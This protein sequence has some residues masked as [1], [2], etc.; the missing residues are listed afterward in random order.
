M[1]AGHFTQRLAEFVTT[2]QDVPAAALA[3][4]TNAVIDTVGCA[5]AGLDEAVVRLALER[6]AL[7]GARPVA[8]I[9][10]G[11]LASSAGLAALV[12]G[13]AAHV[14]DYDDG[15][16]SLRAHPSTTLVPAVLAWGEAT[17]ASGRAVL[18]AYI[19]GLEVAAKL[20]K[21]VGTRHYLKG[22]HNTVTLGVFSCTAAVG[23]LLG[24]DALQLRR[25]W[26]IAASQSAGM[27]R[28]FGTMVKPF[29]AGQAARTGI[30]A[31]WLASRGMT[32]DTAIWDGP[33]GYLQLYGDVPEVPLAELQDALGQPWEIITPGLYNKRWPCCGQIHRALVG[34]GDLCARHAIKADEI[35]VVRIGFAPGS[36]AAL[37]YDNPQSGLEGKFSIQYSVAA[38]LLDG[39]LTLDSY[40]DAQV[41]RPAVR[42]M[43]ARVARYTTDDA[44][45]DYSGLGAYTD[46]ALVTPR[47]T[48]ARRVE[49]A[50]D[51]PARIVTD[52]EHDEKFRACVA[53]AFGAAHA[54]QLLHALRA[55]AALPDIGVLQRALGAARAP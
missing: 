20:T 24:L 26:G 2:P 16:A 7:E 21:A 52:A 32:A 12:N 37:I 40:A 35:E 17:G 8:T 3:A 14:H 10:G 49:A 31:A 28:N 27:R 6:C 19:L 43:M 51:R 46:V 54:D 39:V 36:D 18:T 22:W 41:F 15:H 29:H 5:L 23:H 53:P 55:C 25:A 4:A 42:A 30:E 13:V 45:K 33:N 34:V 47:G 44:R 1:S 48:F 38:L 11:G 50:D 9:W